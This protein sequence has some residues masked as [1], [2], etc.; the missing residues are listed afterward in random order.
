MATAMIMAMDIIV[1]HVATIM[2][3][4]IDIIIIGMAI[5]IGDKH[6]DLSLKFYHLTAAETGGKL[7][8]R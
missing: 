1:I 2:D 5:G 6:P 7:L 4:P 3:I 8:L